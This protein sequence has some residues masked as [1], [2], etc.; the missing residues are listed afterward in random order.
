MG[1]GEVVES[2]A[3]FQ[4]SATAK[5]WV[6]PK[7]GKSERVV[8]AWRLQSPIHFMIAGVPGARLGNK[9]AV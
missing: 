3:V 5:P 2:W 6:V 7:S 1:F 9:G 8:S 4:D